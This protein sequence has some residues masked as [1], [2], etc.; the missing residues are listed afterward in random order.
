[1]LAARWNV[2]V[3]PDTDQSV[4]LY[5]AAQGKAGR[6]GELSKFIERAT[7][8]YLFD[9]TVA[10]AKQANVDVQE[11]DLSAIV[12]EALQWAQTH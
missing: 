2:A 12:T 1:M 8:A 7:R 3:S 9:L 6:K 5:L 4:R 11:A 10:Q